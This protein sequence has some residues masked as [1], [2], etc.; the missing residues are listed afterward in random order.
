[1]KK[2]NYFWLN[3]FY[4]TTSNLLYAEIDVIRILFSTVDLCRVSAALL[5]SM[6]D[7]TLVT[8]PVVVAW[9]PLEGSEQPPQVG[10]LS[11]VRRG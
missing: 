5:L 7:Y 3:D 8:A 2:K 11:A 1:M 9:S 6:P 10:A 4:M